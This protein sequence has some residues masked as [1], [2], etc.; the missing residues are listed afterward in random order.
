MI[1][2]FPAG[3]FVMEMNCF[4]SVL[5]ICWWDLG[6]SCCL[7]LQG[8]TQ[9]CMMQI[10]KY[11]C[12]FS[13]LKSVRTLLVFKKSNQLYRGE[14]FDNR[15]IGK[16]WDKPCNFFFKYIFAFCCDCYKC[17]RTKSNICR[18]LP[19]IENIQVLYVIPWHQ[20]QNRCMLIGQG[21]LAVEY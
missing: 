19:T 20:L 9:G 8:I 10:I 5:A 13:G 11:I 15:N 2:W 12:R 16:W 17:L 3:P 21:F 1:I 6:F 7:W 14:W 4:A 18:N